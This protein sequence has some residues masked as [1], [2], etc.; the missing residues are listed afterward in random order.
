MYICT[1]IYIYQCLRLNAYQFICIY[2]WIYAYLFLYC[3]SRVFLS[4]YLQLSVLTIREDFHFL[5]YLILQHLQH[6]C[7]NNN[8]K[9][10]PEWKRQRNWVLESGQWLEARILVILRLSTTASVPE[11]NLGS[12]TENGF[13]CQKLRFV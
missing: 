10:Y 13:G 3:A 6:H 1:C 4:K 5:Q 9:Y 11:Q 2:T 8:R 7:F 12:L